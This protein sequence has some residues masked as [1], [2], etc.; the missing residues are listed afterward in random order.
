MKKKTSIL[1]VYG[2][3]ILI[4]III[5]VVCFCN[6][7]TSRE[8]TATRRLGESGPNYV[9]WGDN[10]H[11][12]NQNGTPTYLDVCG[13]CDCDCGQ[14]GNCFDGCMKNYNN[15][16]SCKERRHKVCDDGCA[17]GKSVEFYPDFPLRDVSAG[18]NKL[19][20][21]GSGTWIFEKISST[22]ND[23]DNPEY[24]V[25]GDL[26]Y[27]QNFRIFTFEIDGE[28]H[29]KRGYLDACGPCIGDL[30]K[31]G[32]YEKRAMT[33]G[34][35]CGNVY[36]VILNKSPPSGRLRST[37][38]IISAI[39]IPEGKFVEYDADIYLE[40]QKLVTQSSQT[41]QP[42]TFLDVCG[43]CNQEYH[44]CAGTKSSPCRVNSRRDVS[45]SYTP[46]RAKGSGTWRIIKADEED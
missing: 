39:G 29:F 45:T 31:D 34:C 15:V 33:A 28:T 1:I 6:S 42:K 14:N 13:A 36:D 44:K 2:I 9:Q 41:Q 24:I 35:A 43:S 19:R 38:K 18:T 25:Y 32:K 3:I 5:L 4:V 22:N 8:H 23:N 40:N 7:K 46:T 11:L 20:D 10:I 26:V 30:G 37:W 16:G 12:Q 27:I 21:N 17:C